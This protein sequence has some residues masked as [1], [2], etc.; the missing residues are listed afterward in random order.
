MMHDIIADAMSTMRNGDRIGKPHCMLR[1]ASKLLKDV[2]MVMQKNGYIGSFEL[3]DDGKAGEIKVELK[4]NINEGGVVKPRFPVKIGGFEKWEKRYLPAQ[5][6]GI[7]I[8][9]TSKGVMT[10]KDAIKGKLGGVLIA[11]VY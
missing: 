5:D 10:H 11:Y 6:F 3:I 9:S 7:L 4:G 1:P 2:L 8:V